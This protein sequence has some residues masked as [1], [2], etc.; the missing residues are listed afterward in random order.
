VKRRTVVIALVTVLALVIATVGGV[1]L[2]LHSAAQRRQEALAAATAA[3]TEHLPGLEKFVAS[4]TARPWKRAVTPE[5]LDD[6]AFVNALHSGSSG[7]TSTP[8]DDQDDMGVT[9]AAMGLAPSADDFWNAYDKGTEDNVVGFYD[10]ASGRLVVRGAQWSPALEYTLVHELT[11]ANQDQSFDLSTMWD[12]TRTD[13]ESATTLRGLVEGEASLVADDYYQTQSSTWR[14]AV[15]D[16][17]S[18]ATRSAVPVVD[19]LAGFP[20]QAGELFVSKIRDS[21]GSAAVTKAYAAPPKWS[22][23][24][25]NPQGWLAGTLPKVTKPPLP[26][27]VGGANSDTADIGTLGVLGLWMTA[28]NGDPSP[29]D[30]HQLDGWTGDTYVA[31]ENKDTLQ[32]CFTDDV[33]FQSTAAREKV[34]AYL[35]PWLTK[36][37][38]TAV[39]TT[40][41]SMRLHGCSG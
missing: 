21:G 39:D 7:G 19:T 29:D 37:G 26:T 16:R 34:F 27:R 30:I 41:T 36:S 35:K 6:A 10:D 13:D 11:H 18:S 38:T 33:T 12:A 23:D 24:L 40:P 9:V 5:V 3:V 8:A 1:A 31:T 28:R 32:A 25:V 2:S 22:R 20:Y 14:A 15:D 4:T 17:S